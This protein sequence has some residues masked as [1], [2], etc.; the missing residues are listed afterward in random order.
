MN[1]IS[2][3]TFV[4]PTPTPHHHHKQEQAT[5]STTGDSDSSSNGDDDDDDRERKAERGA[6]AELDR[7]WALLV[8]VEAEA[9]AFNGREELFEL[10]VG[11]CG[12]VRV[13]VVL[14]TAIRRIPPPLFSLS[15]SLELKGQSH[16]HIPPVNRSASTSRW[17][18]PAGTCASSRHVHFIFVCSCV[19][20]CVFICR[21]V[22]G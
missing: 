8:G 21:C 14:C 7:Q 20:V 2:T 11:G 16:T 22:G 4:Y 1:V 3:Y 15:L 9:A 12:V 6:Y 18:T 10:Q 19:C 13:G 5:V 17:A